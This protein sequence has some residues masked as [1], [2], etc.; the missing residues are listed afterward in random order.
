MNENSITDNIFYIPTI[1][2]GSATDILCSLAIGLRELKSVVKELWLKEVTEQIQLPAEIINP[3]VEQQFSKKRLNRPLLEGEIRDAI[4]KNRTM[5]G[6][7]RYLG[8]HYDTLKKYCQLYDNNRAVGG[9]ENISAGPIITCLP[10]GPLWQ[11][12]R[13]TKAIKKS[14]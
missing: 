12:T 7:A 6:A 5:A 10:A 9:S 3:L 14:I 2:S 13:G 11:P 8:V 4:S 1:G